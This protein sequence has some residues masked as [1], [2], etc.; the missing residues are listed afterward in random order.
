MLILSAFFFSCC[1]STKDS[2]PLYA[3]I[4]AKSLQSCPTLCDPMAY[5]P[6]GSSVHE[7]RQARILEWVAMPSSRCPVYC[8]LIFSLTYFE[9][10]VNERGV[11]SGIV[12]NLRCFEIF[13]I[14]IN[15]GN[16]IL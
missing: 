6:P 4:H 2:C 7:I 10:L 9:V 16:K 15:I 13:G 1:D 14:S 11:M 8:M 5:S 3:Y 12:L